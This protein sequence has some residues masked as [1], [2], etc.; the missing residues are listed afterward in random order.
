L[1]RLLERLLR[2]VGMLLYWMHVH[3]VVIW[4][5]RR[6]PRVLLYHACETIE[7]DYIRDL[8]SNT[9]PARFDEHLEFLVR[10]YRV[11]PLEALERG[12]AGDRAVVITFDDG[13]ASVYANAFPRLKRRGLSATIYLTTDVVDN[14]ALIWINELNWLLRNHPAVARPLAAT[15]FECVPHAAIRTV[16]D[17]ACEVY[18]LSTI[19]RLVSEIRERAGLDGGSTAAGARL[20]LTWEEVAEMAQAGLTFGNHTASHPNLAR[21]GEAAQSAEIARAQDALASHVG[22][23]TSLAYPFGL[24]DAASR[25]VAARVGFTSVMEVGGVN[26]FPAA[27]HRVARLP[28]GAWGCAALFA[29]LEVVAPVKARARRLLTRFRRPRSLG[30]TRHG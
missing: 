18:Q 3:P 27:L 21:L 20:Y 2:W 24:Y 1:I 12:A 23:P 25:R 19:R 22:R 8:R 6:R 28:V 10:H 4:L 14:R 7:S 13:Y 30:H 17:R 16:L 29:E 15:T 11:V 9:P 5:A 26:D